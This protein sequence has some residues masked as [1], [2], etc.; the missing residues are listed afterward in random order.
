MAKDSPVTTN[1]SQRL[2]AYGVA[3]AIGLSLLAIVVS[4]IL[5]ATGVDMKSGIGPVVLTLPI[6]TLPLGFLLIIVLIIVTNIQRG[7]AA[8]DARN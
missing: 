1:G 4:L 3:V 2:L 6:F 5:T 8:K 7:R